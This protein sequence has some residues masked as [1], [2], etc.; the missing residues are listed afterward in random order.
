VGNYPVHIQIVRVTASTVPGPTSLGSGVPSSSITANYLHVAFVTQL[1]PA[2]HLLKDRES[3]LVL[4]V[5][6]VGLS[7]GYYGCRLAG[8]YL[9]LPLF[10]PATDSG[11]GGVGN[12]VKGVLS[13]TLTYRGSAIMAIWSWNGSAEAANGGSVTVHAWLLNSDQSVASGTEVV[14]HWINGRYYVTGAACT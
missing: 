6:K 5:N 12:I 8:S 13:S 1:D 3:C 9:G 11:Q 7:A 14:A 2:T 10:V 4:D